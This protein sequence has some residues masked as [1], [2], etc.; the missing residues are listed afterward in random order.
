VENNDSQI[1]DERVYWKGWE[2]ALAAENWC[3]ARNSLVE[4]SDPFRPDVGD[5]LRRDALSVLAEMHLEMSKKEFPDNETSSPSRAEEQRR[6]V[7]RIFRDCRDHNIS[8]NP[9]CFDHLVDLCL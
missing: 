1:L 9:R 4:S 3:E 7:A 8:V 2:M 5:K 6:Y